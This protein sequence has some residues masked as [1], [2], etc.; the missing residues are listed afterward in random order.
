M[1]RLLLTL[2][3]VGFITDDLLFSKFKLS[4][5]KLKKLLENGTLTL[6]KKFLFGKIHNIY[7]LSE[8]SKKHLTNKGFIIYKADI[9]QLEHDYFLLTLYLK[10]PE[11]IQVTWI[12]ETWL[13]EKYK[14]IG[15]TDAMFKLNNK[16]ICVEVITRAYTKKIIEMKKDFA[17]KYADDL[18]II[19]NY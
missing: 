8:S 17:A 12:N 5:T 2:C 11:K 16:L 9:D 10:L 3:N 4:R 18:I 6:N 19:K 13:K 14:N 1:N 7:R 15:T